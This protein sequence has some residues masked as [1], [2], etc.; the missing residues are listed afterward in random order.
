[1]HDL[2][3]VVDDDPDIL[4]LVEMVLSSEGFG[5][6]TANNGRM[7]LTQTKTHKPGLILLDMKMPVMNGW[8]FAEALK[9]EDMA[10]PHIVVMTAAQD[11]KERAEQVGAKAYLSKPFEI[12]ELIA[13]V[14]ENLFFRR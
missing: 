9:Q 10:W 8:Q 7:A 11:A 12:D 4:S 6:V 1:M 2:I 14:K 3:L 13:C 5:V